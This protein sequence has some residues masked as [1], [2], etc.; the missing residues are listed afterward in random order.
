MQIKHSATVITKIVM[1]TPY[2]VLSNIS[3][4]VAIDV[5]EN[6]ASAEWITL[7]PKQ[8]L[9]FWPLY[10]KHKKEK[11]KE[12]D[13]DETDKAQQ[14]SP[15]NQLICRIAGTVE[16]STPFSYGFL[17]NNLLMVKNRFGGIYVETQVRSVQGCLKER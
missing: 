15:D 1:F 11:E 3:E 7:K 17:Q 10:V 16:E 12:K 4:K 14:R 2:Y 8:T 6:H 13:K 9:P 5:R